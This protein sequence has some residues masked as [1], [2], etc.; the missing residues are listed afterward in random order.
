MKRCRPI[1]V[2]DTR[3]EKY[4]RAADDSGTEKNR[5]LTAIFDLSQRVVLK[6]TRAPSW[7]YS[8]RLII[9]D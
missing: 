8:N 3:Q 6:S 2:S 7:L 4:A 5:N 9:S 1:V